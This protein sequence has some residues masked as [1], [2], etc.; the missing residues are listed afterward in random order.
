MTLT[1]IFN[2]ILT[3][4]STVLPGWTY[5]VLAVIVIGLAILMLRRFRVFG[6]R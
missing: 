5:Y 4:L 2:D 6:G 3:F 1:N